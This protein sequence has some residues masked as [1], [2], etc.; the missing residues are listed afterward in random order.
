MKKR[1][2]RAAKKK[3]A[4]PPLS[5][6]K[7]AALHDRR[8]QLERLALPFRK[9]QARARA[10]MEICMAE[11]RLVDEEAQAELAPIEA[12]LSAIHDQ[13]YARYR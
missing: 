11:H 13:L 12:E 3:P 4:P 10:A 6:E 7:R 2:K 5:E 9:Q 1:A 8:V